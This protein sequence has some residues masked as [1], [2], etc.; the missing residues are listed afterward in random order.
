MGTQYKRPYEDIP[1]TLVAELV[2]CVLM[3]LNAKFCLSMGKFFKMFPTFSQIWLKFKKIIEKKTIEKKIIKKSDNFAQNLANW[4]MNGL[5]FHLRKRILFEILWRH[6]P[7][8]TKLEYAPG[9]QNW[10]GYEGKSMP[11]QAI[12]SVPEI[13]GPDKCCDLT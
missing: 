5:L 4:Y 8:K 10:R 6:I 11:L 3:T 1:P 7:T 2:S 13:A 12:L 9:A